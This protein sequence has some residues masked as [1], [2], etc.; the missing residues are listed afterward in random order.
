MSGKT[1]M[2]RS[3]QATL[4]I[5]NTLIY[6]S[7]LQSIHHSNAGNKRQPL[8]ATAHVVVMRISTMTSPWRAALAFPAKILV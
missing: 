4:S 3:T 8:K 7:H 6:I 1:S 2:D 5:Y